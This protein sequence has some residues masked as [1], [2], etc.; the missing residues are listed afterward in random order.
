MMLLNSKTLLK[1]FVDSRRL[2]GFSRYYTSNPGLVKRLYEGWDLIPYDRDAFYTKNNWRYN[3]WTN[4]DE[5]DDIRKDAEIE[6]FPQ[7]IEK[8]KV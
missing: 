6:R 3:T 4:Y 5:N 8:I 1:D 7:A 2:V